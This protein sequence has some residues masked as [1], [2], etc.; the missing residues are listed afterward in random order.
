MSLSARDREKMLLKGRERK[1]PP[2][3]ERGRQKGKNYL[4]RREE[5]LQR[6]IQKGKNHLE[7]RDMKHCR[8]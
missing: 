5:T 1:E 8:E 3:K 6:G 2:R 4:E 7:R